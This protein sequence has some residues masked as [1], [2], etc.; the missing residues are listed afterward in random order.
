[1]LDINEKLN[2]LRSVSDGVDHYIASGVYLGN[3]PEMD[4]QAE[5]AILVDCYRVILKELRELGIFPTIDDD[6]LLS[7]FYHADALVAIRKIFDKDNLKNSITVKREWID[8][9][10]MIFEGDEDTFFHELLESYSRNFPNRVE[11][12]ETAIRVENFMTSN[13]M[14]SRHV[15]A[16]IALSVPKATL[17]EDSAAVRKEYLEKINWGRVFFKHAVETI[18]NIAKQKN[19]LADPAAVEHDPTKLRLDILE[20]AIKMYDIDK[21]TGAHVNELVWAVMTNPNELHPEMKKKQDAIILEHKSNT[22]H[23]IE[24]Y[25]SRGQRPTLE[26]CVELICHM[27]EPGTSSKEFYYN[28]VSDLLNSYFPKHFEGAEQEPVFS[29]EQISFLLWIR[30]RL[31]EEFYFAVPTYGRALIRAYEE[32]EHT[33]IF[34]IPTG[35]TDV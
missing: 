13:V 15:Q 20:H 16:I 23:H 28:E 2:T 9:L 29:P 35:V 3:Y 8:E 21:I 18:I 27:V 6:E 32:Y 5:I 19:F 7:S 12:V 14:L 34:S 30:D 25:L 31:S 10:D 24:Y 33:K 22:T 4:R 1:M 26:N 11:D 17:T